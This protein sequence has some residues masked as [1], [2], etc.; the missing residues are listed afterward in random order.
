M[1][2]RAVFTL[3]SLVQSDTTVFDVTVAADGYV[4]RLRRLVY[5]RREKRR[6]SR[7]G[8]Q[9][10]VPL[11]GEHIPEVVVNAIAHGIRAA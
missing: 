10:P 6:I 1:D 4:S 9:R 7:C 5:E 8:C 3:F 11:G 2:D